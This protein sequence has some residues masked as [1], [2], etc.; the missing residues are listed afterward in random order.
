[1]RKEILS[2]M[3]AVFKNVDD[4]KDK[5]LSF[6]ET[7][8]FMEEELNMD[9]APCMEGM[10]NEIATRN[11]DVLCCAGEGNMETMGEVAGRMV[12][13]EFCVDSHSLMGMKTVVQY[14]DKNKSGDLSVK[15][16]RN[17]TS[18]PLYLFYASHFNIT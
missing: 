11:A 8:R 6:N 18:C 5:K 1:M 17:N 2:Q 10:E 12:G 4:N 15:G 3:K 14:L 9:L 16:I 13:E 7:V